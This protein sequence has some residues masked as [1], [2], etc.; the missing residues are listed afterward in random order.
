MT[1]KQK[2]FADEYLIDLNATRA[3]KVAYP[4]IKNDETARV[5]GSRMLTNAN[6]KSYISER[7]AEI[8][9]ENTATAQEVLEYLTRG[10]RMELVEEVVV[11]VDGQAQKV[12]KQIS[13]RDA[14]KCAELLGKRYRLYIDK[15]E[16]NI[17]QPVVFGGENELE[18]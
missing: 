2:R 11:V 15:I 1:E 12:M 3:Y 7:I 9:T 14:N 5:N 4:N 17:T 18:D 13:I 10:M 16:A 8:R 6:V